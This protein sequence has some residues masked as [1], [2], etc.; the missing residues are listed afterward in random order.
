MQ[1]AFDADPNSVLYRI[2]LASG[3][4]TAEF[5][6]MSDL[7][8]GTLLWAASDVKHAAEGAGYQWVGD[9]FSNGEWIVSGE[10]LRER[11]LE[12]VLVPAEVA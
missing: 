2:L 12:E 4:T 7:Q 6:E 3:W 11:I 1:E 8:Y 5:E 10:M 9:G